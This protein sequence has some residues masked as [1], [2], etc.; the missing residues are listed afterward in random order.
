MKHMFGCAK[1]ESKDRGSLKKSDVILLFGILSAAFAL[2]F[3]LQEFQKPGSRAAVSCDGR[4]VLQFPLSQDEA[5]YYLVLWKTE[6]AAGS[7]TSEEGTDTVMQKLPSDAWEETAETLLA[8]SGAEEYNLFVCENGKVRMIR[9]SCPDLI[10]VNH[11]AVS[12]TGECIIC[13]PHRLVIEITGVQKKAD[14]ELDGV[15]Y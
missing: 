1:I 4:I 2:L 8:E 12:G 13:L 9:S 5:V 15:A 11:Q 10:C 6:D 3:V 7:R 14:G